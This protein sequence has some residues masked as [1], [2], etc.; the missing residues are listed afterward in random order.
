MCTDDNNHMSPQSKLS[1][2]YN[3]QGEA[4]ELQLRFPLL[5]RSYK[6]LI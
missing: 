1:D 5:H 6:P 3:V 2:K 4:L